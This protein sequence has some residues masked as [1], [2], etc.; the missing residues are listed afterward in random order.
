MARTAKLPE[1]LNAAKRASA[2][3]AAVVHG[4]LKR[5]VSS[6]ATI[7]ST[8][9]WVGLLGTVLGI[10]DSFGGAIN[11]SK[12]S[13]VAAIFDR[14]WQAFLPC[15]VG[16]VIALGAMWSYKYLLSEVEAL[17]SDMENASVQLIKDLGRLG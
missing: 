2:R 13:I 4:E 6:L 3:S 11:G 14:L 17:D 7:A 9:A 1:A 5:G 10:H 16:L 12:E 15:A 8:A